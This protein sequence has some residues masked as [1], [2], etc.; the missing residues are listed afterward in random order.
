METWGRDAG[1]CTHANKCVVPV[2]AKLQLGEAWAK[3]RACIRQPGGGAPSMSCW[4]GRYWLPTQEH[5]K[6][7]RSGWI[8]ARG[9]SSG[10]DSRA[11]PKAAS[12]GAGTSR[13]GQRCW[14]AS[15]G[16]CGV[17][18]K[19]ALRSRRLAGPSDAPAL[20]L[21]AHNANMFARNGASKNVRR[22]EPSRP[23]PSRHLCRG[24]YRA[25]SRR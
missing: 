17:Q 15:P 11:A 21:L 20:A 10:I 14:K 22:P 4:L 1:G 6:A 25:T 23:R 12:Q 9:R 16:T 18:V 7:I 5:Q 2:R 19:R 3:A 8:E 13:Q 24:G